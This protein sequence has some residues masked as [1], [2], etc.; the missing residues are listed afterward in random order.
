MATSMALTRYYNIEYFQYKMDDKK[1]DAWTIESRL[2][3]LYEC[4][5]AAELDTHWAGGPFL[6]AW[7]FVPKLI[8][9]R[10]IFVCHLLNEIFYDS[11]ILF[12]YSF[13]FS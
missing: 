9:L 11:L 13:T 5:L 8:L 4:E 2:A 7:A 6:F 10:I 1:G 12:L 3:L